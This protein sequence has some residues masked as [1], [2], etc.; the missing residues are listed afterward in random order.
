MIWD[1][2]RYGWN[3]H[4]WLTISGIPVVWGERA[5]GKTLP[6]DFPD[7]DGSL[8]IDGSAELGT[9]QIDRARGVSVGMFPEGTR[10]DTGEL[11]NFK[12]GA[13][14]VAVEKGLPVLPVA[15]EGTRDILPRHGW[16]W[17]G[18]SPFKTI[19][20]RILDPVRVEDTASGDHVGLS[21]ACRDRIGEQLAEWRGRTALSAGAPAADGDAARARRDASA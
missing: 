4:L 12:P 10:S 9:D 5:T 8:V 15:I 21:R 3:T 11:G 1:T 18:D 14:R 2:I 7:E 17:L 6:A 19:K 20:V 16:T 13:F